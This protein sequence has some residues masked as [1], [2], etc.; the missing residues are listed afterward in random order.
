MDIW[1]NTTINTTINHEISWFKSNIF[2]S[3]SSSG[4][5]DAN[6]S[7][8]AWAGSKCSASEVMFRM[9]Q[10]ALLKMPQIQI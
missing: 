2:P 8:E 3:C 6:F 5:L 10:D 9:V 1:V 7:R 4:K